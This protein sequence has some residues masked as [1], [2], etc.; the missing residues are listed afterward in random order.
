[1]AYRVIQWGGGVNGQALIRSIARHADLELVGC[2]VWSEAKNGVD[3][4]TLA[5]IAPLGV[6]ASNEVEKLLALDADVVIFCGQIRPDL[7]ANDA[8]I[9]ALLRS[10]KN[11]I[12]VT[13]A[14]SMPMAV[15]GGY[16][17]QF[18]EACR[19]GGSSMA[20]A[21]IN[22]GFIAERLAATAT[23]LCAEVDSL[24]ISE[25]F[26]CSNST[27]DIVFDTMGFGRPLDA[28]TKDSPVGQLFHHLFFQLIHNVA[29]S[30]AVELADVSWTATAFPAPADI[31]VDAGTIRAGTVAAITQVWEGVPKDPDQIRISK[32]T[33]WVMGKDLPGHP[34]QS[35]WQ[36]RIG[37]KPNLAVNVR[38]DP[39]GDMRHYS[40]SMVGSAIAVIP[41]VIAAEPGFLLPRIY[42]PFRK[43]F[44]GA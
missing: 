41:E 33:S 1:M 37:G 28:W 15:G 5:G 18:E 44:D 19:I 8:E 27:A 35:G 26:D 23:G 34:V 14:H 40:E 24:S 31:I 6:T 29:R 39:D 3:A 11:V 25:S 20:A 22:P 16:G 38:Y 36:I 21:G 17:R 42:A 7:R 13:G 30:L 32:H 12:S 10:G 43:R 2:R 9:C 4:G